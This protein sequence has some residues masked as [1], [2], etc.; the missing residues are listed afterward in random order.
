VLAR[1]PAAL[2]KRRYRHRLRDGLIVL[3]IE[4]CECELAEA[5]ITSERLSERQSAS[6]DELKHAVENVVREWCE[7]WRQ[8]KP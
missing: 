3:S 5:L 1:T 6:R 7:R 4:V 2:K 8:R